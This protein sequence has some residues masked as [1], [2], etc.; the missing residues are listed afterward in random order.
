MYL[1]M[2]TKER[3][4]LDLL[5]VPDSPVI[6]TTISISRA[7]VVRIIGTDNMP[8]SSTDSAAVEKAIIASTKADNL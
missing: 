4:W 2:A 3:T 5:A 7:V 1:K 6:S 8:S